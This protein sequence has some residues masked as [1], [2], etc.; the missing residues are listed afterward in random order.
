[1]NLIGFNEPLTFPLA[2]P[3]GQSFYLQYPVKCPPYDWDKT[4][5]IPRGSVT[6]I[7]AH[8]F[9]NWC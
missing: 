5:M 4:F 3:A 8:T 9:V 7:L 2:P 6:G 1:M